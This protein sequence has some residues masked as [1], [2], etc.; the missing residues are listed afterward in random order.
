M[1]P[2]K[3]G[4]ARDLAAWILEAARRSMVHYG[5]WFNETAHQTGLDA[6]LKLET[7][8]GDRWLGLFLKRLSKVLNFELKDGL[9]EPLLNMDP[10][11]LEKVSEAISLGWLALD[12]VWF[13]ALENDRSMYDAQRA[14]DTCWTRF[15][16]YEAHRIKVVAGLP[17][18]G[19]LDTLKQALGLRLYARINTQEII[20]EREDSFVFVMREC[21]V[22]SART[23]KG[24]APYPCKQGGL[25]EYRHFA[26]AVDPRIRTECIACPPDE[27]VEGRVCSWRFS[28][29]KE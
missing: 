9:P 29:P 28:L 11:L 17:D 1:E 5:L 13:Q 23:R 25:M 10:A 24:L 27:P 12:G 8:A 3:A 21:R 15:S 6:A 18:S 20:E 26:W 16:P 19:G 4:D 7:E 22:Q 2:E 14:N